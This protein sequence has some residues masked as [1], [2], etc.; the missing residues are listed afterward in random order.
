MINFWKTYGIKMLNRLWEQ[1]KEDPK[2]YNIKVE[3]R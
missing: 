2:K 3:D 1:V